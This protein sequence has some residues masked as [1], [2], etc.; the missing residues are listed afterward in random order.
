[1]VK[2][3]RTACPD[4]LARALTFAVLLLLGF[5]PLGAQ[6]QDCCD[7]PVCTAEAKENATAL[8]AAYAFLPRSIPS[9]IDSAYFFL[10][11]ARRFDEANYNRLMSAVDDYRAWVKAAADSTKRRL[12]MRIQLENESAAR[13]WLN[14]IEK[15]HY[16][17]NK[18]LSPE[19]RR[20]WHLQTE[21]G[22]GGLALGRSNE[23]FMA[24]AR[25]LFSYTFGHRKDQPLRA[26]G[27]TWR[28]LAGPEFLYS[29]RDPELGLDLRV[30]HRLTDFGPDLA[31][32]GNLHLFGEGLFTLDRT[33][34]GAG[35]QAELYHYGLNLGALVDIADGSVMVRMGFVY[36]FALH[37]MEDTN[38]QYDRP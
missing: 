14:V 24:N 33:W 25:G 1:M 19:F 11:R 7:D 37:T 32:L 6:A 26:T 13:G 5:K 20:G 15:L 18:S 29:R 2:V 31:S 30:A 28:L 36:R 4:R 9:P 27:G 23:G 12:C 16:Q 34:A 17:K 21:L 22:M 35:A 3:L 10:D 8:L 38:P